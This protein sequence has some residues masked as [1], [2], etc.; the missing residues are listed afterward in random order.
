MPVS[1]ALPDKSD[2]MDVEREESAVVDIGD[3]YWTDV[4]VG[5]WI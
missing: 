1:V 3:E 5:V 2:T 4:G